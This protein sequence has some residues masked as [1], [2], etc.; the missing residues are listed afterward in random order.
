MIKRILD[1]K[2]FKVLLDDMDVLF[3][4]DNEVNG[5]ALVKHNKEYIYNAF[6]NKSI[7]AWD[8]FIWG[9]LN[10]FNKF[11]AVIAFIND[12]N[13]KFGKEIFSEY[14]WLSNNPRVGRKL[15]S[16]AVSFAKEKE[17]EYI[18][19]SCVEAHPKSQKVASFYKRMGFIKD[20]ETYIAK[21]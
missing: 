13:E 10:E 9:N 6:G 15:L 14:L 12:K 7:L 4:E 5:H 8:F 1:P 21:L 17:F 11:D 18:T 19:M 20:S 3:K 16:K 2:E